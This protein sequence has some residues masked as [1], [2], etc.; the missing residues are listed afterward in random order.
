ME[1][2]VTIILHKI[3]PFAERAWIT[4]EEKQIPYE[5]REVSLTNKQPFFTETYRKAFGHDPT[6][7]GKV[8]IL[9]DGD[10]TLTESDL[11]SWYL[12]EKY[13]T[14]TPL[15]PEDPFEK[16]KLRHFTQTHNKFVGAFYGF[17]GYKTKSK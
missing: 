13:Q 12:A 6:S 4:L 3:C 2:K 10:K 17:I 9:I 14:G 1:Q 16:L 15:I 7:D 11:I 8:P 5:L